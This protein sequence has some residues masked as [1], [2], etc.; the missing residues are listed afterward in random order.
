MI[1][2]LGLTAVAKCVEDR[3]T[4]ELLR[5][6]GCDIGGCDIGQ[7]YFFS[8]RA[9]YRIC[10]AFLPARERILGRRVLPRGLRSK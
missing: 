3:Y 2:G 1:H 7:G 8:P 10:L 6:Y 4:A 5:D 9:P